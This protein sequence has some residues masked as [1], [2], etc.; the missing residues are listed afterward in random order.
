MPPPPPSSP[1][2]QCSPPPSCFPALPFSLSPYSSVSRP[3]ISLSLSVSP[4]RHR[5]LARLS[6]KPRRPAAGAGARGRT[7]DLLVNTP[8]V[9]SSG[10]MCT[11]RRVSFCL[12]YTAPQQGTH[13]ETGTC[14]RTRG[15]PGGG[16]PASPRCI[17]CTYIYM[18]NRPRLAAAALTTTA[19]RER[20]RL[21]QQ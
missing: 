1:H 15:W 8:H 21:G 19:E 10:F 9:P 12:P 14:T 20:E 6:R 4:R 2:R 13:S 5:A 7:R 3:V 17:R 18:R 16:R 11:P